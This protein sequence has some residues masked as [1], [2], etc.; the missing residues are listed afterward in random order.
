MTTPITLIFLMPQVQD[1]RCVGVCG[2]HPPGCLWPRP[3]TLISNAPGSRSTVC[4]C[5][6]WIPTWLP[7]TTPSWPGWR[8]TTLSSAL[9]H[10]PIR[11]ASWHV[12]W[13]GSVTFGLC[14][15]RK[16][17]CCGSMTYWCGSKS[18]CGS[19]SFYFHHWPSR[20]QQKTNFLKKVFLHITVWR[21]FYIIF[22]R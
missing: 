10:T 5:V 4:R 21:Y 20:C 22:Q 2:E 6:W 16:N 19:G 18:G 12:Y 9:T 11:Y 13:A 17:Q 15:L 8:P 14:M 1:L 3:I 7:M